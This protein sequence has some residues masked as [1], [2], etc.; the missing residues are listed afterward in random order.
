MESAHEAD[1]ARAAGVVH[2]QLDGCLDRFGAGVAEVDLCRPVHWRDGL[3][4]LGQGDGLRVKEVRQADVPE[5]AELFLDRRLD[6]G[7]AVADVEH[8]HA[9]HE[10]EVAA[11]V[12]VPD[13][14]SLG[15][16]DDQRIL[17]AVR[18][19]EAGDVAFDPAMAQR[20]GAVEAEFHRMFS[21]MPEG[22]SGSMVKVNGY[23]SRLAAKWARP[24]RF[25][26]SLLGNV[27]T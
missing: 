20:A 24:T 15:A 19:G 25:S 3:E 17:A 18:R 23:P 6:G 1:E 26:A 4:L 16:V 21:L 22:Y 10:V 11:A 13:F 8:G 2:G 12:H 7:V 27:V 5:L 14:R 9:G